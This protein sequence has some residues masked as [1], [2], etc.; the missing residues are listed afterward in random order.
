[1]KYLIKIIC[2][3]LIIL[4]SIGCSES[5]IVE[6]NYAIQITQTLSLAGKEHNKGLELIYL[7]LSQNK[8]KISKVKNLVTI[9]ESSTQYFLETN[10]QE[11][12]INNKQLS[13]EYALSEIEKINSWVG[14]KNKA[15]LTGRT[16]SLG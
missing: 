12:I 2:L 4:T 11:F 3:T 9:I 8:S 14:S 15:R 10:S 13:V 16:K 1:M 5:K 6:S 7:E